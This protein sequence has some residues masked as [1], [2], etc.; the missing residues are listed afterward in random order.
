MFKPYKQEEYADSVVYEF[1]TAYLYVMYAFMA[2]IVVGYFASIRAFLVSGAL[3][4]ILY[5]LLV[6]TQYMKLG[7]ITKRA[8]QVNSVEMSGSKWSFSKPLRI[9]INREAHMAKDGTDDNSE[10]DMGNFR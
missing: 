1:K 9:K 3:L 8:A 6:S 10:P 2:L 5:F 4:L 7:Q